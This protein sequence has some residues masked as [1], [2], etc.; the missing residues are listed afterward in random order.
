MDCVL[1]QGPVEADPEY[2]LIVDANNIAAEMDDEVGNLHKFAKDRYSKRFPELETLVVQPLDYLL[3][4]KEL[5]NNVSNFFYSSECPLAI[6]ATRE[7]FQ[8]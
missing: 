1:L 4:A 2:L 6:S 3:T 5:Q 8:R 7:K